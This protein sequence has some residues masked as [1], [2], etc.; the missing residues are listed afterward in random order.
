MYFSVAAGS[1]DLLQFFLAAPLLGQRTT[2]ALQCP[3]DSAVGVGKY[4]FLERALY[5]SANP[6]VGVVIEVADIAI[7]LALE[8]IP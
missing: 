1:L 5:L 3:P 6:P 4:P 7:A 2:Q 8:I